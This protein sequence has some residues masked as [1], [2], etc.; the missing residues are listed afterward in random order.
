M[1]VFSVSIGVK[2]MRKQAAASDAKP[3]C[4]N[5]GNAFMYTLECNR[6][7]TPALAAVSPNRAIGPYGE[8]DRENTYFLHEPLRTGR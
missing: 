8:S 2:I 4:I 7:K 3:V 5:T 6:A 1:T